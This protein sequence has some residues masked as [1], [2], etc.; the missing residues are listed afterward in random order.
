M[1][2]LLP[3]EAEADTLVCKMT[4]PVLLQIEERRR[5][6]RRMVER[7][8]AIVDRGKADLA[9]SDRFERFYLEAR[10]VPAEAASADITAAIASSPT[11]A[12]PNEALIDAMVRQRQ[13]VTLKTAIMDVL[14]AHPEGLASGDLLTALR[15]GIYPNLLRTSMSPQLSRMKGFQVDNVDGRWIL[16]KNAAFAE[17][18][19][20]IFD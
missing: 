18:L 14:K 15:N 8:T 2:C 20:G 10:G 16:K 3:L 13:T 17:K 12:P 19:R 11:A 6:A 9:E 4:D 7:G 5:K 1:F